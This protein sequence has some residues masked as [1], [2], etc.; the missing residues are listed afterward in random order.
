VAVSRALGRRVGRYDGYRDEGGALARED[1]LDE[2][3]ARRREQEDGVAPGHGL[4]ETASHASHGR[5]QLGVRQGSST[6]RRAGTSV[7]I[8]PDESWF[9]AER[10]LPGPYRE[11]LVDHRLLWAVCFFGCAA[12][13]PLYLYTWFTRVSS[14]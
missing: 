10:L 13:A 9:G 5:V 2:A 8:G 11:V 6:Q 3:Q 1:E 4:E 14:S 12:E 7:V